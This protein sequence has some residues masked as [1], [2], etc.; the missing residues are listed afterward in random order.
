MSVSGSG[1]GKINMALTHFQSEDICAGFL[2]TAEDLSK[3]LGKRIR[4]ERTS[5]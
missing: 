4:H 5:C 3:L 1:K 2:L